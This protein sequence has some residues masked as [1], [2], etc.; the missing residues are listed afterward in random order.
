M[1][2]Y[3]VTGRSNRLLCTSPSRCYSQSPCLPLSEEDLQCNRPSSPPTIAAARLPWH[4]L[5]RTSEGRHA[6]LHW[7]IAAQTGHHPVH[8]AIDPQTCLPSSRRGPAFAQNPS[9]AHPSAHEQTQ[10]IASVA[11]TMQLLA[12]FEQIHALYVELEVYRQGLY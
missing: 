6:C 8:H 7:Q 4:H 5:G 11:T 1:H 3:R 2:A 9:E 12:C 10:A